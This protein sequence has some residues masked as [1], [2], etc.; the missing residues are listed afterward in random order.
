LLDFIYKTKTGIEILYT[1]VN[2]TVG[3]LHDAASDKIVSL[4]AALPLGKHTKLRI[5]YAVPMAIFQSFTTKPVSPSTPTCPVFVFGFPK[6]SDQATSAFGG[7]AAAGGGDV[8]K[9]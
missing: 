5:A 1:A 9:P 3:Q 6:P 2:P 4:V 8:S 7:G